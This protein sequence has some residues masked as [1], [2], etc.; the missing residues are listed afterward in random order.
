MFSRKV[1]TV[2]LLAE[3]F[4]HT[5]QNPMKQKTRHPSHRITASSN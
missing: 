4:F 2:A 1:F 3:H 5:M